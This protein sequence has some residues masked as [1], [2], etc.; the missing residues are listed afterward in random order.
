MLAVY[1]QKVQR[2]DLLGVLINSVLGVQVNRAKFA[3]QL[4]CSDHS[5]TV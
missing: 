3:T 1:S 4:V 5:Q 2:V